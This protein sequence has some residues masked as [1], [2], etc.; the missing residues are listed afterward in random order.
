MET[1]RTVVE[2]Y[3]WLCSSIYI[4][5]NDE[6]RQRDQWKLIRTY[7]VLK[8]KVMNHRLTTCNV[9]KITMWIMTTYMVVD[10]N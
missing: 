8:K 10:C 7:N 3:C 4:Q 2:E 1:E 6:A 9:K 5:M